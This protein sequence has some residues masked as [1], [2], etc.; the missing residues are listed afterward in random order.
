MEDGRCSARNGF[1]FSG[2]SRKFAP[3]SREVRE[4][5]S[6]AGAGK[7]QLPRA[8]P[9]WRGEVPIAKGQAPLARGSS[10]CQG[11]SSKERQTAALGVSFARINRRVHWLDMVHGFHPWLHAFAPLGLETSNASSHPIN[12]IHPGPNSRLFPFVP[13]AHFVVPHSPNFAPFAPFRGELAFPITDHRSL[14]TGHWSPSTIFHPSSAVPFRLFRSFRCSQLLKLSVYSV[15][16]VYSVVP[17]SVARS[18]ARSKKPPGSARKGQRAAAR[19]EKRATAGLRA[20][21]PSTI[22]HLPSSI[23]HRPSASQRRAWVE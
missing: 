23:H 6:P 16:S 4:G 7:F 12:P 3:P 11:P 18:V 13:F 22:S 15:Y 5:P 21:L 14:L 20:T 9:R 2:S 17:S 10:N 8:K 19:S 1:P